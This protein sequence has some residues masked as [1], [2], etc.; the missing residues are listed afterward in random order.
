M[1]LGSVNLMPQLAISVLIVALVLLVLLP[2]PNRR[3]RVMTACALFLA[4]GTLYFYRRPAPRGAVLPPPVPEVPA[5]PAPVGPGGVVVTDLA[6]LE[7]LDLDV[8]VQGAPHVRFKDGSLVV[9]GAKPEVA[10]DSSS[11]PTGG[12]TPGAGPPSGATLRSEVAAELAQYFDGLI[13]EAAPGASPLRALRTSLK[14][15][16]AEQRREVADEVA[17]L[18]GVIT[19]EDG[20]DPRTPRVRVKPDEIIRLVKASMPKARGKT[21]GPGV[22]GALATIGVVLAAAAVLKRVPNPAGVRH[23]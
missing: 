12:R 4:G 22:V 9:E 18:R 17:R 3:V 7:D 1:A 11:Q 8:S 2:G 13:H 15:L 6:D 23:A 14:S 20:Q 21:E 10:L 19:Q 5:P 16:S